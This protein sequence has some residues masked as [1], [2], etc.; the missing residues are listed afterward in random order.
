MV[1]AAA[2]MVSLTTQLQSAAVQLHHLIVIQAIRTGPES[3]KIRSVLD[4]PPSI[5][6]SGDWNGSADLRGELAID[7]RITP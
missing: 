6:K 4:S 2:P 7:Q 3:D 5:S 1:S